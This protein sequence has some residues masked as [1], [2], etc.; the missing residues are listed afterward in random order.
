MS[1]QP[2]SA[3]ERLLASLRERGLVEGNRSRWG[4]RVPFCLEQGHEPQRRRDATPLQ[5]RLVDCAHATPSPGSDLCASWV[6]QCFSRLGYGVV[7]GDAALLYRSYCHYT[8][9]ADLKVAMIVATDAHPYSASGLRHGHVGFYVGDNMVMDCADDAVR[10]V[11]L[12]LWLSAY[13]LISEPRWGWLGSIGL[14]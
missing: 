13:G 6:E 14:S 4:R 1:D 3:I 8:D 7:L 11:P 10:T 9:P 12:E 5:R 2:S